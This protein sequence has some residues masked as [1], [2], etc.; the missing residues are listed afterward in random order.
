MYFRRLKEAN[1][2]ACLNVTYAYLHKILEECTVNLKKAMVYYD[3]AKTC[4]LKLIEETK[5]SKG[6]KIPHRESNATKHVADSGKRNL[7]YYK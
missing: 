4:K 7:T 2:F 3:K 1:K 6:E 5:E